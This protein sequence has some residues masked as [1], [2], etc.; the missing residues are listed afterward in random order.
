MNR[1]PIFRSRLQSLR[2]TPRS[3]YPSRKLRVD[4]VRKK[5]EPRPSADLCDR[6]VSKETH[7]KLRR[8]L[9]P[10][11]GIGISEITQKAVFE[12]FQQA[13][14]S[15]TRSHEGSGVGLSI[16]TGVSVT[17]RGGSSRAGVLRRGSACGRSRWR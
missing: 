10:D 9:I 17:P 2:A 14:T 3:A 15:T 8:L 1:S 5:G 4:P 13:D 7:E 16:V 12:E 6:A 11:D